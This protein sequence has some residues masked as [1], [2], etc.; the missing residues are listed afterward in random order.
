MT[1]PSASFQLEC[2]NIHNKAIF[3][4]L[5]EALDGLRPY[6]LRGPP[7]PW[8]Q[9]GGRALT[10]K[11]G[12]VDSIGDLL[13]EAE[14]RVFKWQNVGAGKI[15]TKRQQLSNVAKIEN[16]RIREL[17]LSKMLVTEIEESDK[18]W[19][20]FEMEETQIKLD[21]TDMI[22]SQMCNETVKILNE[23]RSTL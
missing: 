16:E 13:L 21:I 19:F 1:T 9:S 12:S 3:D 10:F 5:N 4:G 8:S 11:Y 6:G 14:R 15:P 7:V 22:L 17:R 23:L 18:N 2:E 20:D